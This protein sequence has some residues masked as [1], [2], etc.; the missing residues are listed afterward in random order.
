MS[1]EREQSRKEMLK[2]AGLAAG[3]LVGGSLLGAER[4]SA[5]DGDPLNV[6]AANR[7][8]AGRR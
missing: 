3:V 2:A 8:R 6:G 5:A 4:A 7:P 1:E